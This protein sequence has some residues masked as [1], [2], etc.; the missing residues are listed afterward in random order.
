[1]KSKTLLIIDSVKAYFGT[2]TNIVSL[3]KSLMVSY[4]TIVY[5]L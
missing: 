1:M 4:I 5:F 2:P 3:F